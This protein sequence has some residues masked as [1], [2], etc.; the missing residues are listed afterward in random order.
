[1]HASPGSMHAYV[2]MDL[3]IDDA[4]TDYTEAEFVGFSVTSE[5]S[6][7]NYIMLFSTGFDERPISAQ[8]TSPPI[9]ILSRPIFRS[10]GRWAGTRPDPGPTVKNEFFEFSCMRAFCL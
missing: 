8:S 7:H 3:S 2:C 4:C 1:M 9:V 10:E 5:R 6:H